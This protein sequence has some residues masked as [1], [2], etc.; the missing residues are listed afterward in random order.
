MGA[1]GQLFIGGSHCTNI[2]TASEVRGCLSI[3]DTTNSKVVVP[4][5]T[6]DATGIQPIARRHVVYVCQNGVLSIYDTTTDK[7]QSTQITL[8]GQLVDVKTVD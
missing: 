8:V 4:P 6:G 7:L 5:E 1:N 3:F 2:N